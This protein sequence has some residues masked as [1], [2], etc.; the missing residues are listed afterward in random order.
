MVLLQRAVQTLCWVQSASV[1]QGVHTGSQGYRGP[2]T[3]PNRSTGGTGLK[4]KDALADPELGGRKAV[5][6]HA[7]R[8]LAGIWEKG[9]VA[10]T[11]IHRVL[12]EY[13]AE[14]RREHTPSARPALPK[15]AHGTPGAPH[16]LSRILL[17]LSLRG[18]EEAIVV[19][20][21]SGKWRSS[22]GH[23]AERV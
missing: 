20:E 23:N 18:F 14:V 11:F 10:H 15:T 2:L 7:S 6:S 22:G 21:S 3:E 19:P 1:W 5:I 12:N 9:M 13:L 4:L 17:R 16:A 8:V